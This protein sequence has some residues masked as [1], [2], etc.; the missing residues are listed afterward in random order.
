V[1]LFLAVL[2]F[3]GAKNARRVHFFQNETKKCALNISIFCRI[4]SVCVGP[5]TTLDTYLFIFP[6]SLALFLVNF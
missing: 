4:I 5:M 6:N 1:T 2:H 3:L